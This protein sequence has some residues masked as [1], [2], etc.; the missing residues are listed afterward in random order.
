MKIA[1]MGAGR[2]ATTLAYT[3]Q[4][5]EEVECYAVAARSFERAQRF[6]EEY[7]FERAYGSYE[8]ML[9]D[10]QVELV[11]LATPHGLHYEH[12]KLCIAH[13]KPV[14][15]EKA[16]TLNAKQAREIAQLAKQ[17]GVFVAE[18]IWTRYM[19]SRKMISEILE[20]G[21]IGKVKTLTANLCYPITH[22]ERIMEPALG[23]GALLDIGVYG[24][25]FACMSFKD[26]I[27]RIE[28]SVSFAETGVDAMESISLFFEGDKM[29]VIT[30]SIY[31]RSDRQGI[32]YGEK[33][34]IVVENINNP[35]SIT[36]YDTSDQVVARY[37]VPEQINGYEYEIAECIQC[38]REGRIESVSM[39]LEESI[40]IMGLMDEVREKWGYVFPAEKE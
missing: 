14:L 3:M 27:D 18:A 22:K 37:E 15:C 11:Y 21:V 17:Q 2:I 6:Q 33:G 26:A 20:S 38:I 24:I 16:F 13:K 31:A 40:Y 7:G 35:Q 32:F 28:T 1:I 39:P 8:E 25:N 9:Q 5:M 10:E 36:V 19:P 23:G 34:Y 4:Q 29:A 30:A 12:M